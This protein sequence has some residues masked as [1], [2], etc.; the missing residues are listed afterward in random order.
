MGA[1]YA[2]SA[3]WSG[4]E[5]R[6]NGSLLSH[7]LL[8]L[9]LSAV[10]TGCSASSAHRAG[11]GGSG[12]GAS[13][14]G[15][16]AVT[17]GQGT[18]GGPAG[19][20]GAGA[21]GDG[22]SAGGGGA[23][24]GEGGRGR[25]GG[26][27][28]GLGGRG[29]AAEVGGQAGTPADGGHAMGGSSDGGAAGAA[30][31]TAGAS[32]GGTAGVAGTSGA[33]GGAGGMFALTFAPEVRYRGGSWAMMIRVGDL[34]GDG[35]PDVAA[36]DFSNPVAGSFVMLN[37]GDGTLGVAS[38]YLPGEHMAAIAIGDFSG[39][40]HVDLALTAG[41][42]G[43]SL[44]VNEGNGRFA[45]AS[46][47]PVHAMAV[48]ELDV[49]GDGRL[50]L[51]AGNSLFLNRG[52]GNFAAPLTMTVGGFSLAAGDLDRDG[53]IDLVGG[54]SSV[55]VSRNR[56]DGSFDARVTYQIG[57]RAR[58]SVA[59]DVAVGDVNRDGWPDIATAN[60][61]DQ[62]ASV[63]LNKGDGT[64]ARAQIYAAGPWPTSVEIADL[65]GDGWPELVV[66]NSAIG[67]VERTGA[68]YVGVY[69]NLGDGTFAPPTKIVPFVFAE[70]LAVGDLNGDQKLDIV[71][72]DA[73]GGINVAINTSR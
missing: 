35:A 69:R 50:D 70:S 56:G 13:G 36:A 52:G 20:G 38:Q 40:G 19:G 27:D 3:R 72:G 73:G 17:N 14:A 4:H 63:L 8:P 55:S 47:W 49:N 51:V 48:Q 7:C 68:S 64:F 18:G 1:R 26:G 37:N 42:Q 46:R 5:T 9:A 39:D 62:T 15:G 16:V 58:G 6:V 25:G 67:S 54:G 23:G 41:E 11:S 29:G 2:R 32:G 31:G 66:A 65:N 53:K 24:S 71:A 59:H 10:A 44:L 60:D 28:N 61:Y 45:V 21:D 12:A 43:L 33:A 34:N 30:G 57:S 22:G